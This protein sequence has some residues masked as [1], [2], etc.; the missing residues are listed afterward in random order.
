MIIS[1]REHGM[2]IRRPDLSTWHKYLS[3]FL[4]LLILLAI[5][6]CEDE[7]C[8]M[9]VDPCGEGVMIKKG[10]V[11]PVV[12]SE[13]NPTLR[14]ITDDACAVGG[15]GQYHVYYQYH[16]IPITPPAFT[17][18]EDPT[19][20]TTV[21]TSSPDVKQ[22]TEKDKPLVTV[23]FGTL[24]KGMQNDASNK[25]PGFVNGWWAVSGTGGPPKF[26]EGTTPAPIHYV[27]SVTMQKP[28]IKV[29]GKGPSIILPFIGPVIGPQPRDVDVRIILEYQKPAAVK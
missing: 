23:K 21:T 11:E 14:V 26:K 22:A 13:K 16:D 10:S 29:G 6:G 9:G 24:E 4:L 15:I 17:H 1:F 28:L 5:V 27:L 3:R 25:K 19:T 7:S 18:T 2:K 12:L 20:H 8:T